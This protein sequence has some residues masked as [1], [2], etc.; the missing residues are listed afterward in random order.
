MK[1][2]KEQMEKFRSRLRRDWKKDLV[3]SNNFEF[4]RRELLKIMLTGTTPFSLLRILLT[5]NILQVVIDKSNE[6]VFID[7]YLSAKTKKNLEYRP[8]NW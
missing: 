5:D 1:L 6:N 2:V 3:D 7:I 8:E 4:F